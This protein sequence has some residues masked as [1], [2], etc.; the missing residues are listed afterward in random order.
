MLRDAK[1]GTPAAFRGVTPDGDVSLPEDFE[2]H[3]YA[4][5][6]LHVAA[7]IEHSLMV[8]YL[9]AAY[10]LTDD[11]DPR[12]WRE[13]ILGIAKEEMGHLIT[14]QNILRAIG[15]PIHLEREDYP[16]RSEFYPFHF[17]LEPLTRQSLARYIYAE[18]PAASEWQ[19]AEAEEI[20]ELATREEGADINRVGRLYTALVK[21]FENPQRIRDD[22]F[23]EATVP[24]QAKPDEYGRGYSRGARGDQSGLNTPETPDVMIDV[25]RNRAEVVRALKNIAQQGEAP[26]APDQPKSH[27]ARFRE[28]YRALN[29]AE[30][31]TRNIPRNPTTN[32]IDA[33]TRT[34]VKNAAAVRWCLLF[35]LRYRMLLFRLKHAFFVRAGEAVDLPTE[36]GNLVAWTFAEMYNLRAIA[37]IIM[38][39]PLDKAQ[40]AARAGPPFEMPYTLSLPDWDS[41][42]WRAHR[43]LI[44]NSAKLARTLIDSGD[45]QSDYLAALRDNDDLADRIV[46]VLLAQALR[47]EGRTP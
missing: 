19:G 37:G 39:L 17:R 22:Q 30:P 2:W 35:D 44:A 12:V 41:D 9:Y 27:F 29:G 20:R 14:V 3:D 33:N 47:E 1:P 32:A 6:L 16:F 5:F 4:V 36:R 45:V 10:S 21:L 28:I 38:T 11:A 13:V 26:D 42:K 34:V 23:L 31:P 18:A 40:D 24:Y 25:V 8:Q 46:Q 15:A 7:E 43:D